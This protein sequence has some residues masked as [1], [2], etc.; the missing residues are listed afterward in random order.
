M[1]AFTVFVCIVA[2]LGCA[3][4]NIETAKPI[5]VDINM[6]VDI[7]QHVVEDVE[8]IE[9]QIYGDTEK[10]LNCLFGIENVYAEDGNAALSAAIHN[11]KKR[12]NK[13]E[14]YFKKGYIGENRDAYL[15]IVSQSISRDLRQEVE[16]LVSAENL[17]RQ[18]IYKAT[19]QKNGVAIEETRKVFF[20]DHYNRAP[21]GY[22]FEVFDEGKDDYTWIKK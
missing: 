3:K 2:V 1:R 18:V 8:S 16:R 11:R 4:V 19:A 15:E 17:D 10:Q 12:L 20:Q 22:W 21:S 7:Y 9:D 5:K 13:V 14:Y 6:R